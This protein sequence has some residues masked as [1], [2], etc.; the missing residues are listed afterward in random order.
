MEELV[1]QVVAF[2]DFKSIGFEVINQ[3]NDI[4]KKYDM[5]LEATQDFSTRIKGVIESF[6]K[7]VLDNLYL[8]YHKYALYW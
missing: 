3:L 4:I 8:L 6:L 5:V 2:G 1:R 7:L